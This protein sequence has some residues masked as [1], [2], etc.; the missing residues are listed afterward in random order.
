MPLACSL[1]NLFNSYIF[2][3]A[4]LSYCRLDGY[5]GS[6]VYRSMHTVAALPIERLCFCMSFYE[7]TLQSSSSLKPS[8]SVSCRW[9]IL[10]RTFFCNRS[11]KSFSITGFAAFALYFYLSPNVSCWVSLHQVPSIYMQEQLKARLLGLILLLLITINCFLI[12]SS[13]RDGHQCYNKVMQCPSLNIVVLRKL[14][15]MVLFEIDGDSE[16]IVVFV[17]I[18]FERPQT[19]SMRRCSRILSEIIGCLLYWP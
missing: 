12:V 17:A 16:D 3:F 14:L 9:K 10:Y 8:S 1:E 15:W 18:L 4:H 5:L 19:R 2:N 13:C 6:P 11:V 7:D